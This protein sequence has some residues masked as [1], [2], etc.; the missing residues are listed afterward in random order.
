M[1]IGIPQEWSGLEFFKNSWRGIEDKLNEL[2][3]WLPGQDLI[4]RALDLLPPEDVRV[5]ILGQDPYPTAGHPN[6]LAFSVNANVDPLPATLRNIFCELR[7]EFGA[8]PRTGDLSFWA[9]QGVLLLNTSLSVMP[10]QP[11]AHANWGWEKLAQEAARQAKRERPVAFILW[12]QEAKRAMKGIPTER[13]LVIESSH[14]SP[15]SANKGNPAFMGSKPF[16]KVNA[17]LKER[18]EAPVNWIGE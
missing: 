10:G 14:P 12:G 17:W 18:N 5:I 6:G 16:S 7:S 1:A 8:T 2:E 15:L 9:K 3:D 4:F 13:D 11:Q